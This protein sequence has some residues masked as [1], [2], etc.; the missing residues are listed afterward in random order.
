MKKATLLLLGLFITNSAMTQE[1]FASKD[2]PFERF[3]DCKVSKDKGTIEILDHQ[4]NLLSESTNLRVPLSRFYAL[5]PAA[6]K[7]IESNFL[8]WS[9][10]Q[11]NYNIIDSDGA[12]VPFYSFGVRNRVNKSEA[13]KELMSTIDRICDQSLQDFKVIGNFQ[14]ELKIGNNFFLDQLEVKR[15]VDS[16]FTPYVE[17]R[18]IVPNSFE[19]KIKSL[20]YLNGTF[21][22]TT[23]VTEG[24]PYEVLFTGVIA[25]DKITNGKAYILPNHNLLGE[26]IG[27]RI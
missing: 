19:S 4:G 24:E 13:A 1:I 5:A 12:L 7:G 26:F 8:R 22:F 2:G 11:T 6:I 25:G 3:T 23:T 17:G 16:F 15:S 18:Y 9:P 27:R 14:I 21:S 10:T 20:N